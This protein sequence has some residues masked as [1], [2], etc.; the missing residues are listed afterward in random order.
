MPSTAKPEND[1]GV[2]R[3]L[4]TRAVCDSERNVH[5]ISRI[6]PAGRNVN[7]KESNSASGAE[8]ERQLETEATREIDM[9]LVWCDQTGSR[10]PD[11]GSESGRGLYT[12]EANQ[13]ESGLEHSAVD[14][15]SLSNQSDESNGQE[16]LNHSSMDETEPSVD[17]KP[18]GLEPSLHS[19]SSLGFQ[20]TE[21]IK[22]FIGQIPQW[23]EERD[24]LPMFEVF[25]PIHELVILRDRFTRAHKGK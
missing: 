18:S 7:A 14:L 9:T 25:G 16:D 23:I 5:C 19:I 17:E 2:K 20:E 11:S 10:Q 13:G 22:L 21:T 3:N 8:D 4:F 12:N 15:A 24:I 6:Y 1:Q